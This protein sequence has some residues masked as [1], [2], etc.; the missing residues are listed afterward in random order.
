MNHKFSVHTLI[1]LT[2]IAK[3]GKERGGKMEGEKRERRRRGRQETLG[4]I[5]FL[6]WV[7]WIQKKNHL[8]KGKGAITLPF[9]DFFSCQE[10]SSALP[11][12]FEHGSY[13]YLSITILL[14]LQI[15]WLLVTSQWLTSRLICGQQLWKAKSD[16][17]STF[18]Y[19]LSVVPLIRHRIR[20]SDCFLKLKALTLAFSTSD[21]IWWPATI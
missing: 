3:R 19:W 18:S 6:D 20:L 12:C 9:S 15:L 13:S 2:L 10:K 7:L 11:C 4:M 21:A 5:C 1:N 16:V 17:K 8:W 14:I